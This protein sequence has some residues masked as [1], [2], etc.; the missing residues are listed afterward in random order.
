MMTSQ[1]TPQLAQ[2]LT[3]DRLRS[4]AQQR[5]VRSATAPA[6]GR[7]SEPLGRVVCDA[8]AGD[9]RAWTALH[10]RYGARV[11][12]VARGYR[13][14]AQDVDDVAQTTWLRLVEH[15]G[16]L[17]EASAIGSWLETT[18]RR[19]SLKVL[20]GTQRE[21]PTEDEMLL[22][23]PAEPIAEHR[24]V[25][26]ER[27]H[28]LD[29]ALGQLPSHQRRLVLAM[30]AEPVPSYTEI[31]ESLNMP[32]GSIGPTRART[33]ARL[34]RDPDLVSVIGEDVVWQSSGSW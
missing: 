24:L 10:D 12:A 29:A 31:S 1:L 25:S 16:S 13:L 15:I 20:R 32:I 30:T 21:R 3:Q 27:R 26:A 33:L 7:P 2:T 19:E 18:A 23:T 22:D 9:Q 14:T 4:A 11:R 28:A 5:V 17:R 6:E 34:R 8:A